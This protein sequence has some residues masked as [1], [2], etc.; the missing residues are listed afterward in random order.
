MLLG[1]LCARSF[2]VNL[3]DDFRTISFT[4]RIVVLLN[5]IYYDWG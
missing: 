4:C 1:G 2:F 5:E 3:V